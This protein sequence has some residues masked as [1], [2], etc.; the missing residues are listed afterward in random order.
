MRPRELTKDC[1]HKLRKENTGDSKH[2]GI[3]Q[4]AAIRP[5]CSFMTLS[6][7]HSSSDVALFKSIRPKVESTDLKPNDVVQ[8]S[9]LLHKGTVVVLTNF[10]K[11]YG[12]VGRLIG[13]PVA[14]DAYINRDCIN[15]DGD[16][17]IP[18]H[19]WENTR[20]RQSAAAGNGIGRP[21]QQLAEIKVDED[22]IHKISSLTTGSQE[23]LLKAK[24]IKKSQIRRFPQGK[25]EG[26]VFDIVIAD[27][28]DQIQATLFSAVAEKFSEEL[29][30]GKVYLF[31]GGEVRKGGKF[32][33]A[34]NPNEIYFSSKTQIQ[35]CP[36]SDLKVITKYKFKKI[37]E[38]QNE[39]NYAQIDLACVVSK[40]GEC[41]EIQLKSGEMKEKQVLQVKD[42]S[43]YEMEVTL[44]GAIE[45]QRDIRLGDTVV[46]TNLSVGEYNKAKVLNS[47]K[48]VTTINTNPDRT[49]P[50]VAEL[51]KWKEA[52]Q[53]EE[54][55]LIKNERKQREL[56]VI[57]IAQLKKDTEFLARESLGNHIY[58]IS[59][60]VASFGS[61]YTYDKCPNSD[62]YKKASREENGTGG[63]SAVCPSHGMMNQPPVPKYIGNI[64]VV[65]HSDSIFL[66]YMTDSVG[67]LLFGCD[68]QTIKDM[69]EDGETLQEHLKKRS[70][71]KFT[72]KVNLKSDSYNGQDRIKYQVHNCFDQ[73]GN[74]LKL[75][76]ITLVNS[77][78]RLHES[79]I[80]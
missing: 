32:N 58:L 18:R 47:S 33:K 59:G 26:C 17:L 34:N 66:N 36:D 3:L 63:I 24:V 29:Q 9:M 4:V 15:P 16:I 27:D 7:G 30:V 53:G 8:A 48:G 68:S 6:D 77:I 69:S 11:V 52:G 14:Y 20:N 70:N 46:F 25:M 2:S 75:E 39:A 38:I 13:A 65:D 74:R 23:F 51:E 55:K 56:L 37:G 28:S 12:N 57:S 44:W 43:N 79:L 76:N 31:M 10:E 72:F 42:D 60:Y 5:D 45:N 1:I 73:I 80:N 78:N 71:L 35:Q 49:I 41:T 67:S 21:I 40:V 64:K 61:S 62:C 22:D 19:L 50:R 54:V